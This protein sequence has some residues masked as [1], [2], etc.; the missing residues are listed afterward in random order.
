M[1]TRKVFLRKSQLASLALSMIFVLIL[2]TNALAADGILDLTFGTNGVVITDLGGDSDSARSVLIQPD[3]K[4]LVLATQG[5]SPVLM[6]FNANGSVDS[7]FGVNGKL[8]VNFRDAV[9]LQSDGKL[10]VADTSGGSLAVARYYSN[11]SGLDTTFGTNG[12]GKIPSNPGDFTYLCSD[13]VIQPDNKIVLVGTQESLGH[14]TTIIVARFTSDGEPDTTF[15]GNGLEFLDDYNFPDS[16]YFRGQAVDIQ[17]DGKIVLSAFMF[18]DLNTDEQ[19]GLARLMPDGSPDASTFG[20]NG[21]GTV[22]IVLRNFYNTLGG[23]AL[24][25][26]GKILVLGNVS[27]PNENLALARFNTDGSL[28]TGFG[29]NG[30]LITDFG[31]DENGNGLLIQADG[32]I[33]VVGESAGTED[34]DVLLIRYN[35]DG[36]LDDTFG[37]NG[38]VITDLGNAPDTGNSIALQ[39]DGKLVVGGSS[40]GNAL[41]AR[42]ADEGAQPAET[43]IILRSTGG[44][45]GWIREKSENSNVG[46]GLNRVASTIYV[47]DDR[48][49]RQ[50]R[51]VLSFN[52]HLIPD[53]AVITSAV[54]RVRRQG[55]VGDDPFFT[56]GLLLVDIKNSAF[57][58]NLKLKLSDFRAKAVGRVR[59]RE[60]KTLWYNARLK[61]KDLVLINKYGVT[62]FRLRFKIDDNDDMSDDYLKFF[63]GDAGEAKQPRLVITYYVP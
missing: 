30:I 9:G 48:R 59:M 1:K 13:L 34:S 12:I 35:S 11:G 52:T 44:R 4:I 61:E 19:F 50:Y 15:A 5:L 46:G 22:A 38:K 62:Q 32:K 14:S 40:D 42:Y 17:P 7:D 29:D 55:I 36:S 33:V 43:K 28:D 37:V 26:D 47:G 53:N 27:N 25:S 20:T 49:D 57:A 23:L 31:E 18:D 58:G 51:S 56:H 24:Q 3:G 8:T 2:A 41:L 16:Y 6:R 21:K 60:T 39:A 45:D 54:V 63:S 10:I